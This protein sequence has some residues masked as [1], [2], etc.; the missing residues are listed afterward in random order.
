MERAAAAM[1]FEEASRLRDQIS[2]LRLGNGEN[3]SID[4]SGFT[5]QHLGA[6]GL[7]SS[8]PTVTPPA[9]W[10]RPNKPDPMT[11]NRSRRT[12]K[13]RSGER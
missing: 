11:A 3:A 9:G 12:N 10:V 13:N 7:G 8:Q 6:M 5:R 1:N 4:A 2:L